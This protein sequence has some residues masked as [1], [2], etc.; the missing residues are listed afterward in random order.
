V[1]YRGREGLVWGFFFFQMGLEGWMGGEKGREVMSGVVLRQR[2]AGRSRKCCEI[3]TRR[4]AGVWGFVEG[5][6]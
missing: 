1:D 6:R 4:A 3:W 5:K 2:R